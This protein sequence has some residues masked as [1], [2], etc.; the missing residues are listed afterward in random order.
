VSRLGTDRTGYGQELGLG[1][2]IVRAIADAHGA[3]LSI[4]PQAGGGLRVEA[5]FPRPA[6]S[7]GAEGQVTDGKQTVNA[8]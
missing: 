3:S 8:Q 4:R 7:S 5:A 6:R 1:L 2:S